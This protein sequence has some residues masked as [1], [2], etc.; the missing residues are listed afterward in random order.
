[1]FCEG[2]TSTRPLLRA[3]YLES[4]DVDI[5]STWSRMPWTRA[6]S[7]CISSSVSMSGSALLRPQP[8]KALQ[9][10]FLLLTAP[11]PQSLSSA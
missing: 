3:C 2:N 4:L 6:A 7:S 10:G 1:M 9:K 5:V 11:A 8:V